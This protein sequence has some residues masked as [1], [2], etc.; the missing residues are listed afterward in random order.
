MKVVNYN[1]KLVH[2]CCIIANRQ[3]SS[4]VKKK[5]ITTTGHNTAFIKLLNIPNDKCKT[6][7]SRNVTPL[8][9]Y[10]Q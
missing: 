6:I 10:K 4:I 3:L 1:L 7:Q 2:L 5:K 9:M 8:L